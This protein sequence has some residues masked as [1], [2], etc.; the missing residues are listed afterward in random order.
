MSWFNHVVHSHGWH[1]PFFAVLLG[2]CAALALAPFYLWPL[3]FP[4]FCYLYWKQLHAQHAR[5]AFLSGWLWG[6][7][8]FLV[9][10]YWLV[11]PLWM[12]KEQFGWLIPFEILF[13]HGGLALF[14]A[15]SGWV[16]FKIKR[17][18]M[19]Q[20]LVVFS[21]CYWGGEWL[22]GHILTGLPWNHVGYAWA[23]Y[24]ESAQIASLLSIYPL[25]LL[26]VLLA[27]SPIIWLKYK[28]L[29][30]LLPI[31]VTAAIVAYG[32]T[33]LDNEFQEPTS[34]VVRVVQA[35]V[36]QQIK[37]DPKHV[38]SSL[39]KYLDMSRG[40]GLEDVDVVV[41]PETSV[42]FVLWE[43]SEW[44]KQLADILNP[45][46]V[47]LTGAVRGD[48]HGDERRVYNSVVAIDHEGKIIGHYDKHHLVPFG[49][50]V[51]LRD[52]LPLEKI[53]AGTGDFTAGSKISAIELPGHLPFLALICYE[54]IFP[55][56]AEDG[57]A[58]WLLNLTN[59]AWFGHGSQPY[60]HLDMSRFRA[61][62]Q[63][64]PMVRAASTGISA[65]I[66]GYGRVLNRIDYNEAGVLD[67]AI[68]QPINV[69]E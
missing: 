69:V 12:F 57:R 42:P 27:I 63:G 39:Q 1:T 18:C 60:Q 61:I 28:R 6:V 26:T 59:D 65:V 51:P 15:L 8:F 41:W 50:Y 36:P 7:G 53:T 9:G 22:R 40:H 34:T 67:V 46:Q 29:S 10:M 25:T 38:S 2:G 24:D 45:E 13:I 3:L 23:V 58:Q 56:Y 11:M 66:D 31:A 52:I 55:S 4:S 37:W 35:N 20:N 21:L 19:M 17:H 64:K 54:V 48:R 32:T 49:E 68:P 43:D 5:Q 30:V 33:R 47:L 62:E 14:P 16:F 44:P